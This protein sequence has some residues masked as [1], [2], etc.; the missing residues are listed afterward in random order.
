MLVRHVLSQLSYAPKASLSRVTLKLLRYYTRNIGICQEEK[1][2]YYKMFRNN[3]DFRE[4]SAVADV[5]L[6]LS[7]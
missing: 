5:K 7:P 2:K 4:V 1:Y 3:R 6:W